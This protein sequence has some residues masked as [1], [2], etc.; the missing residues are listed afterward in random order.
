MKIDLDEKEVLMCVEFAEDAWNLRSQSQ[1]HFGGSKRTKEQFIADQI[2]GKLAECIFSKFMKEKGTEIS[3]DFDHYE[4]ELNT[5]SGD[6]TFNKNG[7]IF[8]VPVDIKGTS[9]FAQ[10][11]LVEE[12]KFFD[13]NTR[14]HKSRAFV[15]IAFDK[16]FPGNRVLRE[17]PRAILNQR[18]SG[19]CKGWAKIEDFYAN[20]KGLWFSWRRGNYP[21]QGRVLPA[22][23]PYNRV[24][25]ERYLQKSVPGCEERER[26]TKISVPLDAELNYGLPVKWLKNNWTDFISEYIK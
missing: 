13:I 7:V 15:L 23:V 19:E 25:L 8:E 21:W 11:L 2:E 24:A 12:Y 16:T 6:L 18:I 10:W 5:D 9:H 1:K 17:N 3:L 14:L 22:A 4:G 26:A 20:D